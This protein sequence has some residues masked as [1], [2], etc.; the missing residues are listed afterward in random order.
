MNVNASRTFSMMRATTTSAALLGTVLVL[1]CAGRA[2]S[3]DRSKTGRAVSAS[4]LRVRGTPPAVRAV[5]EFRALADNRVAVHTSYGVRYARPLSNG[6]VELGIG[7][8]V[9][10]SAGAAESY[11]IVS[12]EDERYAYEKFV[13]PAT[14]E[15]SEVLEVKGVAGA[16][17]PEFKCT[18]VTL[19]LPFPL[20]D[21]KTYYVIAQGGGGRFEGLMVTAAHTAQSFTYHDGV[22]PPAPDNALDLVVMGLRNVEPVG[23]AL[24]LVE[25]GANFS[26]AEGTKAGSYRVTVDGEP[27]RV[28]NIGRRTMVE[29]YIPVGWPYKGIPH[30]EVFLELER[31]FGDGDAV[32]VTAAGS[33]TTANRTAAMAFDRRKTLS[34]SIKVNQVGYVTDSPV[35]IAYLGRWMG[36]FPEGKEDANPSLLFPQNPPFSIC[37]LKTG[38]EV[39]SG[40]AKLIHTSGTMDEGVYNHDHSGEN[41][42]VIDFTSLKEPG[43]YFISVP[44]VGRS[45]P[46]RIADDVYDRAFQVQGYGVFSQRCGMSLGPPYS[47]WQRIACHL[48]GVAPID[49]RRLD[50]YD[51][52]KFPEHVEGTNLIE[53][54]G[55]HHDAG[56]Y[57][58]RSHIDVAQILMDAYEVAPQKFY[59]GQLN[60]PESGNGIPDILDEVLWALRPWLNLQ[61][62]DGGVHNGIES[63]GDP[64]F[65]QSVELDVLGEYAFAKDAAGSLTFA[66]TMAQAARVWRSLGDDETASAFLARG[67][68]AYDWAK[69]H[70]PTGEAMQ[71]EADRQKR[72]R[73]PQ[74]YASAEM[75]LTTG[76]AV[77]NEDFLEA[78]IWRDDPQ[79][80]LDKYKVYNQERAAWAYARCGEDVTDPNL[81]KHAY[82]AVIRKAQFRI[83]FSSQM[84]YV[85]IRAPHAPINWSTGALESWL[86]PIIWSWHL[87]GEE[88]Y[89]MWM[90]R[91]C[92]NTLGANPLNRSYI[93]GA[94]VRTVRAPLHSSRYSHFGEVVMGQQV[95]GPHYRGDGY[96]V[97]EIAYPKIRPDFASLYTF[98]DCHFCIAMNEGLVSKQAKSL[99]TFGLLL[100]DRP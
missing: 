95:Q 83:K 1:A 10:V 18:V 65:I 64:N 74:A 31:P 26:T 93:V 24:L 84:A 8:S 67:R 23:P 43:A 4:A 98:A 55:G 2:Q 39:L 12:F 13:R 52:K 30:H 85:S 68:R 36:S 38:K 87:T 79:A 46:F 57:N 86:M 63:N 59:D 54:F 66:G 75:L 22:V 40:L 69:S 92:D 94:G 82:E 100:P 49:V 29:T 45:L 72:W 76:K 70:R 41:V 88:Q 20:V 48:K 11:R 28:T 99:A 96:R 21:G 33:V 16:S 77:F 78:C 42:Y 7:L 90:I 80:E 81:R 25:F 5:D 56:D 6:K 61:Q 50:K 15:L 14:A 60:L 17:L 19:D 71:T 53:A 89:R 35:K 91:T 32:E 47:E 27:V 9:S 34:N 44:Q 62:A 73:D 58:P 3:A 51:W 37:D 97:T